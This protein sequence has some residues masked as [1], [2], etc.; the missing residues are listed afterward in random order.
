MARFIY[1]DPP[2]TRLNVSTA[3]LSFTLNES[4][5]LFS[6]TYSASF[7]S[8]TYYTGSYSTTTT[9]TTKDYYVLVNSSAIT[10]N[11]PTSPINGIVYTLRNTTA[12]TPI[13]SAGSNTIRNVGS[14]SGTSSIAMVNNGAYMIVYYNNVWYG[15]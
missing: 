11:L 8:V 2:G 7:S 9:L 13:I 15:I 4:T 1:N 3:N 6:S 5:G 12:G 14:A 10:I